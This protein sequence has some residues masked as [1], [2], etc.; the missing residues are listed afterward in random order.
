MYGHRIDG[1]KIVPLAK[2]INYKG[3][4][5]ANWKKCQGYH[6]RSLVAQEIEDCRSMSLVIRLRIAMGMG[7]RK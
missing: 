6:P 5:V 2:P 3:E 7:F 1:H 4:V